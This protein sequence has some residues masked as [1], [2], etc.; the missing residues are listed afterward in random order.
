MELVREHFNLNLPS[1]LIDHAGDKLVRAYTK[2]EGWLGFGD[3]VEGENGIPY[4]F[5][6][7][8]NKKHVHASFEPSGLLFSGLMKPDEWEIWK[9]SVK[10]IVS[11]NVGF[12]LGELENGE[13]GT[14]LQSLK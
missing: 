13:V 4:W 7:D 12:V 9:Y 10:V 1:V 3:G 6:Y 8:E 5:A 11:H 2:I 14:V